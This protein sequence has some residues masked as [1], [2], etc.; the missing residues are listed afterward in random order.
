[1]GSRT[2]KFTFLAARSC[3]F[4]YRWPPRIE[5]FS[6]AG[7][8]SD[9]F[10][11]NTCVPPTLRELH[12]S[13]CPFAKDASIK[14]LKYL[15]SRLSNQLTILSVN[16]HIPY[17]SDNALDKMLVICPNLVPFTIAV[18]C[19]ITHIQRGEHAPGRSASE[20]RPRILWNS[21]RGKE[22][23]SGRHVHRYCRRETQ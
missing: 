11:I 12:I 10:L 20:A 13:H 22:N 14:Y 5:R 17:L 7:G 16:Y 18:E 4:K 15:L 2:S 23:N 9:S 8:V 1:M 19:L 21:G 6:L 3:K